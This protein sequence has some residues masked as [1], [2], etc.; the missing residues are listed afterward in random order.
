MKEIVADL[1]VFD[2]CNEV[3]ITTITITSCGK[4]TD[5]TLYC[6]DIRKHYRYALAHVLSVT[7]TLEIGALW[8]YSVDNFMEYA[9]T[10]MKI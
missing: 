1:K 2:R 7:R 4:D 9:S 10:W 6:R 8:H 5:T 3:L